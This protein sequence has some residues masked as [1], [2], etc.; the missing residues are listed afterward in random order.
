MTIPDPPK[1]LELPTGKCHVSF[2]EIRDWKECSWRHKTKYVKKIDLG[3]PGVALDFGTAMHSGC[4]H[5]L[6]TKTI[7]LSIVVN[8][9][10]AAWDKNKDIKQYSAASLVSYMAEAKSILAD[11]PAWFDKTFPNWEFID[12][13]HYLYEQIGELP[14]AM[15]GYIDGIIVCDGARGK[16]IIWIIDFKTTSWGWGI[17]KKTDPMVLAQLVIYKNFWA[18]KTNTN[19]K[20]IRCGFALLKRTAKPGSHCE[21]IQV[22]VGPVS[23]Q[24]SLKVVTNMIASVKRGIALKN[25]SACTWCDYKDTEHCT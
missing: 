15:K 17:E 6:K 12:A 25:K 5:F 24:R 23:T 7:D 8:S 10:N 9:L 1:F 11:L 20:D 2:S 4:E 13:E 22:S 19:P 16:K 3:K 21:L 14:Y 18:I